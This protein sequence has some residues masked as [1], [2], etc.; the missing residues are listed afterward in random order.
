VGN[1]NEKF[2]L[3]ILEKF[4]KEDPKPMEKVES[5][6]GSEQ[7]HSES[8]TVNYRYYMKE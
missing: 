5:G 4:M 3:R 7:N 6:S 8:A 1:T 2:V